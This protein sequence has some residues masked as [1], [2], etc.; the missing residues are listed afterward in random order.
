MMT[1]LMGRVSLP[2][3]RRR[4]GTMLSFRLIVGIIV[5]CIATGLL[6]F[7]VQRGF[8][9]DGLKRIRE[10]EAREMHLYEQLSQKDAQRE[11]QRRIYIERIR[12]GETELSEHAQE[13]ITLRA[14]LAVNSTPLRFAPT[15]RD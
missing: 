2:V 3:T 4:S 7:F 14:R 9:A 11:S 6:V 12:K 1:E 15:S 10:L 13:I 5:A 8:G